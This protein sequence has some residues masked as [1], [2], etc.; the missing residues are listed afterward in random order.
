M[1]ATKAH[2]SILGNYRNG[3]RVL[4]TFVQVGRCGKQHF[5]DSV[6]LHALREKGLVLSRSLLGAP[7]IG[8]CLWL[9]SRAALPVL[10][11]NFVLSGW[12]AQR[13]APEH[14]R[15]RAAVRTPQTT[16]CTDLLQYRDLTLLHSLPI[17]FHC[18]LRAVTRQLSPPPPPPAVFLLSFLHV[19]LLLLLHLPSHTHFYRSALC[20]TLPSLHHRDLLD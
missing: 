17:L 14:A 4:C 7:V 15:A 8:G 13:S 5:K 20:T 2:S 16:Q 1:P 10:N 9:L 12:W 19:L 3:R 6:R 11:K 18:D